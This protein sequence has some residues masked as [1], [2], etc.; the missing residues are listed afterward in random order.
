MVR[1]NADDAEV[2]TYLALIQQKHYKD[3][4]AAIELYARAIA[5][6]DNFELALVNYASLLQEQASITGCPFLERALS[7]QGNKSH[8]ALALDNYANNIAAIEED[9]EK[10]PTFTVRLFH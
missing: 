5:A 7:L 2:P 3:D 4:D 1:Q 10:E 9:F 6:D 8:H